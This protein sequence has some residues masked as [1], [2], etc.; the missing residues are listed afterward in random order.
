MRS[1]ANS[2]RTPPWARILLPG[3][4]REE[5]RT[6]CGPG[7]GESSSRTGG[8]QRDLKN[9]FRGLL[10]VLRPIPETSGGPSVEVAAPQ[11]PF[12]ALP[13]VTLLFQHFLGVPL[14]LGL[15][16]VT[17]LNTPGSKTLSCRE[18]LSLF[19][20]SCF[21]GIVSLGVCL[22][23]SLGWRLVW[24]SSALHPGGQGGHRRAGTMNV[25][26]QKGSQEGRKERGRQWGRGREGHPVESPKF[27]HG[28]SGPTSLQN[29][30]LELSTALIWPGTP[31]TSQ[32]H[33]AGRRH[34]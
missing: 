4:T 20:Y 11:H 28:P 14:L 17:L 5:Q 15:G 26:G 6:A 31:I 12:L 27:S 34:A 10:S 25:C 18:F 3:Y 21:E 32:T 7:R 33:R 22:H 2:Y 30:E 23:D 24:L 1:A 29:P 19:S 13:R 16:Q 9:H 8:G